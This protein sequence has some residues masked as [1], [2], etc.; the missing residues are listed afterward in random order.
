MRLRFGNSRNIHIYIY[1]VKSERVAGSLPACSLI[2]LAGSIKYDSLV[3]QCP[4][5][6]RCDQHGGV[7]QASIVH[8]RQA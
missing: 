6:H 2:V 4:P 8:L 7:M 1:W 3:C 5:G